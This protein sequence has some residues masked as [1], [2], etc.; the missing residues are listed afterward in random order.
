MDICDQA[1]RSAVH[2]LLIRDESDVIEAVKRKAKAA[3]PFELAMLESEQGGAAG[4]SSS[5]QPGEPLTLAST[6]SR[7]KSGGKSGWAESAKTGVLEAV[8][9][10]AM[11]VARWSQDQLATEEQ[12]EDEGSYGDHLDDG[13]P[14]RASPASSQPASELEPESDTA[15]SGH[16]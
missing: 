5:S 1:S 6:R 10:G 8:A 7:G 12:E 16:T 4:P 13:D 11:E 14:P 9:R 3:S 2:L 15:R